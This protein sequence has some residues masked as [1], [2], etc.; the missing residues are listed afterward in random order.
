MFYQFESKALAVF[1]R[2]KSNLLFFDVFVISMK[3][4]NESSK[5]I[6]LLKLF[7]SHQVNFVKTYILRTGKFVFQ[8][9]A[10]R[11]R[12]CSHIFLNLFFMCDYVPFHILDIG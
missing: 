11:Y 10:Y 5:Y 3:W 2:I 8:I 1:Q 12:Q 6:I 4:K 7:I 9:I